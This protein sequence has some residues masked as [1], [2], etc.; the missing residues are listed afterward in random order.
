MTY[1]RDFN[2]SIYFF[3]K[4]NEREGESE[5]EIEIEEYTEIM[6]LYNTDEL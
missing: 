6:A 3:I 1:C 4:R 2:I 5:C